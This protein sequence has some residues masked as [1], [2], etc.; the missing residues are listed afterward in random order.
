MW[1]H[2]PTRR[3]SYAWNPALGNTMKTILQQQKLGGNQTNGR[4]W[5]LRHIV[6]LIKRMLMDNA[7]WRVL[8]WWIY[9]ESCLS[10][11]CIIQRHNH[12]DSI[13]NDGG[14]RERLLLGP[15]YLHWSISYSGHGTTTT[16]WIRR[17]LRDY[18]I[19]GSTHQRIWRTTGRNHKLMHVAGWVTL[20]LFPASIS[21]LYLK[22]SAELVEK[23]PV[24][25]LSTAGQRTIL[26]NY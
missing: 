9:L 5:V 23:A 4:I 12:L 14:E 15:Q 3:S 6:G 11:F 25:H 1:Q 10:L 18:G 16:T 13:C 2:N 8:W 22:L 17:S 7:G 26:E 24:L 20:N 19:F 21:S